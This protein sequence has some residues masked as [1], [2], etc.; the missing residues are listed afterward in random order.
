MA[1][2]IKN[3][4]RLSLVMERTG[5]RVSQEIPPDVV[6]EVGEVNFNLH[7]FMLVAKSNYIRKLIIDSK[8]PDLSRINLSDIPGGPESFEKAAKFCYGVNF[9][10]TVHNIAALR[11]AAE[12]LQMTDKYSD[13]NL[14]SRT[15]EFLSQVALT[16]L[17]AAAIVLKSCEDLLPMAEELKIV[18]RCVHVAS[19][20]AC[21]E[22]LFSEYITAE[23]VEGGA[24]HP[25][26]R[27][28]REDHRRHEIA[29]CKSPNHR[30][31]DSHLRRDMAP[32]PSPRSF[33]NRQDLSSDP[34]DPDARSVQRDLLESIVKLLPSDMAA[35]P[36]GF[37]C[38]LLRTAI[39]LRASNST[40]HE[41]ERRVSALLEH[42]T[43][44]DL[45]VVSFTYDGE[46]L[47]D[48]ES[49]RLIVAG[50]VEKERNVAVFNATDFSEVCSA[51]MVR[52]AKTVDAYLGEVATC[53]ELSIAKFNGIAN[54]VPKEA[55]KVEDDL[56]RALDIFLK[57]L[58]TRPSA[59]SP[60]DNRA[61]PMANT[62]QVPDLEGLH[63][64]IHDMAKQM[65]IMNKNNGRLMQ[66]FAAANPQLPA[67]PP[68]PDI[69]RSRHSN[70]SRDRSQNISTEQVR[71]GR[72][73]APSPSLR[74]RSSSSESSKTPARARRGRSPHKGDQIEARNK[75]RQKNASHLFTVHQKETESLKDFVKRFN[76]AILE[77]KDPS[78]KV[79]IMAMME[80]LRLGPLFDSLSKN[81]PE[82]LSALQ[83]KADKYI[84]AE[85][86]VEA[87]RRR[88]GKDDHKRKEPDTRRI[89]YREE[90]RNKR[91]DRD[92][93]RSNDR[94]PRTPP[95]RPEF[96]L[97]PLNA[98][99]AQVL[100]EIKHEEFVKW[101]GKIKT[102]P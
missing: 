83:S 98:P 61:H 40:K 19:T 89:D 90:T 23:L 46:R 88:R 64:E 68:V 2:S 72:R 80:G 70:H 51:A 91:L 35:L 75:N 37:L 55:R 29:R 20:K 57:P 12:Y 43:V 25:Q 1:A 77:V 102:D 44:D 42:V 16:S 63:R 69:E 7:K 73:Q 92:S 78:D 56:Y 94:R 101:P 81:V 15:E 95:R 74:E 33:R 45:L 31:R 13:V 26:H 17:T 5:R 58:P 65:R 67:A 100:L 99:V 28:L 50:F 62:S 38:C 39:F 97:P 86:L 71:R 27:L 82:T 41:L 87:K 3:N 66:L 49:V 96:I 10:I 24:I 53:C 84:A 8:E 21:N 47:F 85:E 11:C 48:L 9:E 4:N 54:L 60:P 32:R 93:K 22:A 59:S 76:S 52:V 6:I 79:I 30:E 18:Q 36:I 14:T 34:S